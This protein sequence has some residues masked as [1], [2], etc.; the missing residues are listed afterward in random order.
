MSRTAPFDVTARTLSPAYLVTITR[1]DGT[2]VRFT[3]HD[4]PITVGATT[5][6]RLRGSAVGEIVSTVD[7][8]DSC[9]IEIILGAL[10]PAGDFPHQLD[11]APCL[12]EC[13]DFFDS[14][15]KS[16][17]FSGFVADMTGP[18]DAQRV[19]LEIVG[20]LHR[21]K[22]IIT[23]HFLPTC[24]L[25]LG[26]ESCTLPILP[27]DVARSTAYALGD[28]VRVRTLSNGNPGD[29]ENRI[30][31]VTTAGTT[32][33]SAPTYDTTVGNPTTDGSAV[34]TARQSWMRAVTVSSLDANG[35]SFIVSDPGDARA[36][37][38]WFTLGRFAVNGD[39]SIGYEMADWDAA[40]RQ[41]TSI[42]L[43]GDLLEV[44][45]W[46][47][48]IPGDDKRAE[49]CALKFGNIVNFGGFP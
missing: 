8:S 20:K 7:G 25:S 14:S 13:V 5:W 49:T 32:A 24:P 30:Y 12:I 34:L 1:N 45:D 48:L 17:W 2:A 39:Y 44:G 27:D 46:V 18:F 41:V 21:G 43:L 10:F 33:G 15:V 11:F 3:P 26:D 22:R 36:V 16:F 35:V 4:R 19:T 38:D 29:Y 9:E 23:R 42:M 37:N 40:T 28:F 6:A 31:E 47:D